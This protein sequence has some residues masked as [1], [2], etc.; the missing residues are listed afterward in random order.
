MPQ[1]LVNQQLFESMWFHTDPTKPPQA[2]TR[3]SDRA[4][5]VHYSAKWCGPC[6]R[7]DSEAVDTAAKANGL[8]VWKCDI[9]ANEYTPGYCDVR[10]IPTFHFCVPRK[11]VSELQSADTLQVCTWISKLSDVA[12][13][14]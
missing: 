8:T 9:D 10:A 14:N 1:D 3:P 11:I 13:N 5:I 4:W 2:G 12:S 7:L 6:K